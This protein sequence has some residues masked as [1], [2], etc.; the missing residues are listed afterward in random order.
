[1]AVINDACIYI[2]LIFLTLAWPV[3]RF[4]VNGAYLRILSVWNLDSIILSNKNLSVD[5]IWLKSRLS[6]DIIWLKPC[7]FKYITW[8][9][10][11]IF[12]LTLA[13]NIIWLYL[14]TCKYI[15]FLYSLFNSKGIIWLKPICHWRL[16]AWTEFGFSSWG[17]KQRMIKYRLCWRYDWTQSQGIYKY[18][19]VCMHGGA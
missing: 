5:I 18:W 13:E 19:N 4:H 12:K 15:I 1:M 14:C 17:A 11:G 7:L 16:Q 10:P 9:W 8:L 6:E 2:N 3:R